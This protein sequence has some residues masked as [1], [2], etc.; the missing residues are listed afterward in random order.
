MLLR[1]APLLI[2][3]AALPRILLPL[4]GP[5]P[6]VPEPRGPLE[7]GDEGYGED[8]D[9]APVGCAPPS[10]QTGASKRGGRG[11]SGGGGKGKAKR[12]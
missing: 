3:G 6:A 12:G 10:A 7:E 1:L 11:G 9:D 8:D 5:P 2:M 4:V